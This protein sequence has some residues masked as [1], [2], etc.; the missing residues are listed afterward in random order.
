MSLLTELRRRNVFWGRPV[1]HRFDLAAAASR[2]DI[3]L[4][5]AC[6]RHNVVLYLQMFVEVSE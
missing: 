6:W 3:N 5:N 2:R 1:L 4:L